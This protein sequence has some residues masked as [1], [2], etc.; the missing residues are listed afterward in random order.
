MSTHYSGTTQEKR[1]LD[2][3][4]KLLRGTESVKSR[5]ANHATTES[6]GATPFGTLE[7]LYHLGP[8]NQKEIGQKLLISKSNVV[9]VIDK[10]E[11]QKLVCRERCTEDRRQIF[12]HITQQGIDLI[13]EI[14]PKHVAAITEEL[15]CLTPDEQTELGR[16]CRKLG[17]QDV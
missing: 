13:E 14:L 16:L 7:M 6:I 11:K 8:L 15:S 2:T 4:I 12:V 5:I 9:A 17:L 10:L 3:Y 1:A